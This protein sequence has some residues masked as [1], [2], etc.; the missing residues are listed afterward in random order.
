M[1]P[2]KGLHGPELR[3]QVGLNEVRH[4]A[5]NQPIKLLLQRLIAAEQWDTLLQRRGWGAA[6]V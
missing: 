1:L 2:E 5:V 4:L 3:S 6:P